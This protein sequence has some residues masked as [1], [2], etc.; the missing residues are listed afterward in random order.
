MGKRK[1][2]VTI[3]KRSCLTGKGVWLY[4]GASENAGR[5]AYQRACRKEILRFE[6]WKSVAEQRS[7]NILRILSE[8]TASMP[9]TSDMTQEQKEA[10]RLLKKLAKPEQKYE[11]PFYDHIMEERRRRE[12]DRMI[13][14]KMREREE[15]EKKKK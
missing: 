5:L 1:K 8:C 6:K 14:A 7:R 13:R 4:Q 9:L 10:A 11:S 15:A 12:E 3:I 2:T